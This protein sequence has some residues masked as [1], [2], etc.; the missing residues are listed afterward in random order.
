[1]TT[2]IKDV[3]I[4]RLILAYEEDMKCCLDPEIKEYFRK[5]LESILSTLSDEEKILAKNNPILQ[6]KT[7]QY[8]N[9]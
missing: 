3:A 7:P 2:N 5:Q 4:A 8:S 1:M 6:T 9:H